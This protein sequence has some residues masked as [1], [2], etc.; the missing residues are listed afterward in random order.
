MLR[1]EFRIAGAADDRVQVV[2]DELD[3]FAWALAWA[4]PGDV[5]ALTVHEQ[6]DGAIALLERL[7]AAGW[8]AGE[9]LPGR[10]AAPDPAG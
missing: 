9:P 4:R 6:R 10:P 5:L 8:R 7:L 1:D 2:D 3:A